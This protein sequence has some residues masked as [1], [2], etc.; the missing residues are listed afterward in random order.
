VRQVDRLERRSPAKAAEASHLLSRGLAYKIDGI[1]QFRRL[2]MKRAFA[3]GAAIL[4]AAALSFGGVVKST[5]TEITLKKFGTFTSDQAEKLSADKRLSDIDGNFKGQGLLGGI[6]KVFFPT[7]KTSELVDLAARSIT[8]IDHKRKEF[9]VTPI[10]KF[11]ADRNAV[12]EAQQPNKSEAAESDIRIVKSEFKVEDTGETKTINAFPCKK[13]I[14]R[15]TTDWENLKT[16]DKGT[17]RLETTLW[18]TP[19]NDELAGAQAEESAFMAEY[20]KAMGL[21]VTQLQNDVL[22]TQWI[23]LLN[24]LDPAGGGVKMNTSQASISQEM[25]KI[26]G[27]PIV[28]DGK[29]FPSP[30]VQAAPQSQET[31]GGIGGAL[32]KLGAGLLRKKPNPEAEKAPALEFYTE[33]K[34][35]N[36]TSVNPGEFQVP[37]GYKKK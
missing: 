30:K 36:V 13:F 22:G 9:T 34:A 24:G 1:Y 14:A 12:V 8:Q 29:Y 28:I 19:P 31:G 21:D 23:S 32:G 26:T 11:V 18:T 5:K 33:V 15:W 3:I 2:K 25:G 7:G 6:F 4:I 37:A 27:Y 35:I 20:L 16:G 10:E 17:D